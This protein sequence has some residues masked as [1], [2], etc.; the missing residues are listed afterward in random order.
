MSGEK[1][2]YPRTLVKFTLAVRDD[3][4]KFFKNVKS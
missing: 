4:L 2:L 1:N 3:F